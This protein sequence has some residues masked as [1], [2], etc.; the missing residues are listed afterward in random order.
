[1]LLLC[2]ATAITSSGRTRY[3]GLSTLRPS[4][5]IWPWL[6]ACRAWR[7]LDSDMLDSKVGA[8]EWARPRLPDQRVVDAALAAQRGWAPMP[9]SAADLAAAD[10]FVA[11]VLE[12][13][14]EAG[15]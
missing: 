9:D 6:T 1:M 13:F 14:A 15:A 8:R 2:S 4:T 12:R 10:R 3:D 11:A 5:A 7:F